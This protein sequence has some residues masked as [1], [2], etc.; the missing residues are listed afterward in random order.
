MISISDQGYN[1]GNREYYNHFLVTIK[2]T[3]KLL[4]IFV[5]LILRNVGVEEFTGP[6]Q[7]SGS[8]YGFD[9][10]VVLEILASVFNWISK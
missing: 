9:L 6:R 1:G 10:K 3:G 4:F 5:K 8:R 2:K 7:E